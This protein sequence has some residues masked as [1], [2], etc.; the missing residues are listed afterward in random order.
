MEI[1]HKIIQ[2]ESSHSYRDQALRHSFENL[3]AVYATYRTGETEQGDFSE[4]LLALVDGIVSRRN[5]I[6]KELNTEG[7]TELVYNQDIRKLS[8]SLT[9]YL[10]ASRKEHVWLLFDNLDKGWPI[11]GARPE[12]IL[13]LKSL[14]DATRKL[15]R[16]FE[17]RR[18]DLHAVV[19]LRNDIYE[20]L[21][22][23]PADRG[24]NTSVVLD[25]NDAEVFKEIIRRRIASST[26][27]DAA[28]G[29][30]WLFF[31][32]SHVRGQD[33]FSYILDRTLM[34][35]RATLQFIRDSIDVAVNRGHE[36][37][38][39]DDIL[40]AENS[41]S[42]DSLVD[43]TL[44]LKDI[45]P[46]FTNV[47]YGFIGCNSVFPQTELEGRIMNVGVDSEQIGQVLE[48]LLW[49]GFIGLNVY[50]DEEK[51]SYQFQHNIQKMRSGSALYSY[52]IHPAFRKTL[53]CPD[54]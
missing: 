18:V 29:E 51:Y 20:H 41:Y 15:E 19:F 36:T 39:E 4:R 3:Q 6:R 16:Q 53:G 27:L 7:V 25:W 5:S 17:K 31:F 12:D 52:C 46:S 43:L 47:P 45:N 32:T 13:I 42:D 22:L 54:V 38:K 23:D 50:P 10:G 37:V 28:F 9:D 33:S 48:L 2:D 35:P 24:K 40:Y 30:L 49:L 21:I 26:G 34:R 11:L 1:A 8:D 44:E 14:L